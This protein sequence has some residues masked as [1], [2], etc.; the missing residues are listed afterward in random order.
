MPHDRKG[1]NYSVQ[2]AP[3]VCVQGEGVGVKVKGAGLRAGSMRRVSVCVCVHFSRHV[4]AAGM[5]GFRVRPYPRDSVQ[6]YSAFA[7]PPA[8]EMSLRRICD[9]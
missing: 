5:F 4:S 8:Q 9:A 3:R 2:H 6:L 1:L 7:Q